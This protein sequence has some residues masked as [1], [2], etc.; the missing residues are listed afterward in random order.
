MLTLLAGCA[1][2]ARIEVPAELPFRSNEQIFTIEW[3]LQREARVVRAVGLVRPSFDTEC[4]LTLAI[5]GTDAEGR[6]QSRAVA[7]LRSDFSG[8]GIPFAVEV[9]PTGRETGYVL[10]VLDYQVPTFRTN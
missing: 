5:F 3:A 8:Q 6:I 4:R 1:A 9:I 2:P 10:R 7:Y